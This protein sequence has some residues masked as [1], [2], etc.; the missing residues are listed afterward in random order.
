MVWYGEKMKVVML[1]PP[2]P[3][4]LVQKYAYGR[5]CP[6]DLNLTG[7]LVCDPY[8]DVGCSV[9]RHKF[10]TD[11]WRHTLGPGT[12]LGIRKESEMGTSQAVRLVGSRAA[13]NRRPTSA[14]RTSTPSISIR[15]VW[16]LA[17]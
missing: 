17:S 8:I 2:P 13:A 4:V 10:M 9:N 7:W 5:L 1:P 3:V 15:T 11:L 12:A 6:C 14:A 16:N